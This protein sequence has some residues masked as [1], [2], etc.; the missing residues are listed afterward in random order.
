MGAPR[1]QD[2]KRNATIACPRCHDEMHPLFLYEDREPDTWL[3]FTC[4][5]LEWTKRGQGKTI[6]SVD[7]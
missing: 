6:P 5:H 4:G 3:C 7:Q 2:E 1:G